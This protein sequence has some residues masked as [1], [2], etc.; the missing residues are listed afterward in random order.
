MRPDMRN[1]PPM[2]ARPHESAPARTGITTTNVA[3]APDEL[4]ALVEQAAALIAAIGDQAARESAIDAAAFRAGYTL[5]FAAG[6][7]VGRADAED[8]MANEWAILARKVRAMANRPTFG[9]LE[10]RRYP[11]RTREELLLMRGRDRYPLPDREC[12]HCHGTGMIPGG[13]A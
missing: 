6:R 7:D 9:E 1:G 13:V 8:D 12:S 5:G 2:E 4:R 10:A 11:D 3:D